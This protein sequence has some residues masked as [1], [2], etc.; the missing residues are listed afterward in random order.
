MG[1]TGSPLEF[2]AIDSQPVELDFLLASPVDQTG[3]H[4]QALGQISRMTMDVSFR[5]AMLAAADEASIYE[6]IVQQEA[7]ASFLA[8][9]LHDVGKIVLDRYFGEYY[10]GVIEI[11]QDGTTS[12]YTAEQEIMG[13][14]HA[15]IGGVLAGFS[16]K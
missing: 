15:E 13:V 1:R 14:T 2:G 16:R 4:I 10:K 8:G 3:P 9:M 11:V 7:E 12:I 6:L 5:E